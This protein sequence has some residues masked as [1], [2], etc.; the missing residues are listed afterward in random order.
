MAVVASLAFASALPAPLCPAAVAAGGVELVSDATSVVIPAV[1]EAL[2]AQLLLLADDACE[3][4]YVPGTLDRAA[5]VETLLRGLAFGAARRTRHP[6]R[7]VGL[8]LGREEWEQ[9]RLAC[10]YG[11]P[12][13]AGAR[14]V[15]LPAAGNAETVAL[16][17]GLLGALPAF[18]GTPLMGSAE[19]AASL[20]PADA[21]GSVVAARDLV[22]AAGF[23]GDEPWVLDLLAQAVSL[24]AA[25]QERAGRAEDLES[26]WGTVRRR[27][28]L[29]ESPAADPLLRELVHQSRLFFA[30]QALLGSDQRMPVRAL[31]KLQEKGGGVLR[32]A[33]LRATWPG[34]LV[35]LETAP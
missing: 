12:C 32:G 9:A 15:A 17:Q 10:R 23:G 25:R 6:A 4:R 27:A 34:A 33:D 20:A 18:A 5:H 14:V 13:R 19:E 28:V 22:T 8:V 11:L 29:G 2:L 31:R 7:L 30:A 3:V 24:D 16:W 26:F 35:N 21:L 1:P